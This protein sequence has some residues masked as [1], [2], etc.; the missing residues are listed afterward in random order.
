MHTL[1]TATLTIMLEIKWT[2][3][4]YPA[5]ELKTG[6]NSSCMTYNMVW[7]NEQKGVPTISCGTLHLASAMTWQECGSTFAQ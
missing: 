5:A 4:H 6:R 3:H 1:L 7:H 2:R